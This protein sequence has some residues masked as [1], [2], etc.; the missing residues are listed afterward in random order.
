MKLVKHCIS[1]IYD[2]RILVIFIVLLS[3]IGVL[4]LDFRLP[5]ALLFGPIL[6]FVISS[7]RISFST[8]LLHITL[9]TI[10]LLYKLYLVHVKASFKEYESLYYILY[11]SISVL[12]ISTYM[13]YIISTKQT[14]AFS[15]CKK[16][17]I[18]QLYFSYII[19][20]GISFVFLFKRIFRPE[21]SLTGVI[22]AILAVLSLMLIVSIIY[23]VVNNREKNK[24]RLHKD[25]LSANKQ[26]RYGLEAQDLEEYAEKIKAFFKDSDVFLDVNFNLDKLSSHLE[27][28]KH[29][30]SVCF[31]NYFDMNFYTLLAS[32]RIKEAIKLAESSSIYTWESIAY[33][34][35]YSSRS[36]F[37]KHFKEIT[38]SLPSEF[39]KESP[40]RLYV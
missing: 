37:N 35:G 8:F 4:L 32:Y 26:A 7:R 34:C 2:N 14:Q 38:G 12:S 18:R 31:N 20:I 25:G 13:Y 21:E 9:F 24:L 19:T 1:K 22:S 27:I 15:W 36:T 5:I 33:D 11:D 30:L 29:H 23:V 16:F 40:S 17:Y 10:F 28:P 6:L 39:S 3:Y